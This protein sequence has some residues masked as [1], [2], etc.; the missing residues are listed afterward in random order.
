MLQKLR[1]IVLNSIRY[2]ESGIVAQTYTD[3]YGR[4]SFLIHGVRKRKSRMSAY[5]F[6]PLSLLD[7]DAYIKEG[8][9]L[10]NIRDARSS[11]PLQRLHFDVHKSSIAMFLGEVLHKTLRETDS[12]PQ[13]FSF[14]V[15]AIQILDMSEKGI[16]NFHLIFLLQLTKFLG[17]YPINYDEFSS[18]R[19]RSDIPVS[20]LLD[21]S[22]SDISSLS[23]DHQTRREL[24]DNII[25]YYTDHIEGLGQIRSLEVL[26][27]VFD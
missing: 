6:Q 4:I 24:L 11:L 3:S 18:Y 27:T 13:L 8:R 1:A 19:T 10:Q 17:I 15:H 5:L 21:Y 12:N 14:L 9:D 16:Q 26:K 22:L 20:N 25:R 2:G 7:L 23:L